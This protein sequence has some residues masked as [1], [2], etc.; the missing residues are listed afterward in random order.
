MKQPLNSTLIEKL[1]Y[2]TSFALRQPLAAAGKIGGE[3]LTLALGGKVRLCL[4]PVKALNPLR[5]SKNHRLTKST[6]SSRLK[7]ARP[8]WLK[9]RPVSQ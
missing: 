6:I 1:F 4:C 9:V 8:N 3:A 5:G 2:L 7:P